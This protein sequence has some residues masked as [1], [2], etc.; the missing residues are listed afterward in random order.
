M[1][2]FIDKPEMN[3]FFRFLFLFPVLFTY[4]YP[5]FYSEKKDLIS[6]AI[7]DHAPKKSILNTIRHVFSK[8][9]KYNEFTLKQINELRAQFKMSKLSIPHIIYSKHEKV[10]MKSQSRKDKTIK[11]SRFSQED[12]CTEAIN[13]NILLFDQIE[14]RFKKDLEAGKVDM[15]YLYRVSWIL[16]NLDKRISLLEASNKKCLI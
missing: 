2:I 10:A 8:S 14:E 15:P 5:M 16:R 4:S 7:V 6:Y 13:T 3:F 9:P 12:E 1:Q 11:K